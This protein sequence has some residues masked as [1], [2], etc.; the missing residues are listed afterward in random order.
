MKRSKIIHLLVVAA[1]LQGC[2]ATVD[3]KGGEG[4]R[5]LLKGSEKLALSSKDCSRGMGL[6][7]LVKN[8]AKGSE[9]I[10][11]AKVGMTGKPIEGDVNVY[12]LIKENHPKLMSKEEA[13][14]ASA[15]AK[16]ISGDDVSLLAKISA[17][18][19]EREQPEGLGNG[20]KAMKATAGSGGIS[21]EE[22][23]GIPFNAKDK[24][25]EYMDRVKSV[26]LSEIDARGKKDAKVVHSVYLRLGD[27]FTA[28]PLPDSI[29]SVQLQEDKKQQP[30]HKAFKAEIGKPLAIQLATKEYENQGMIYVQI[31]NTEKGSANQA[32]TFIKNEAKGNSVVEVPTDEIAAGDYWMT[33]I[34]SDHIKVPVSDEAGGVLCMEVGTGVATKVSVAAPAPPAS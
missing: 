14:A 3:G 33:V 23:F 17:D 20:T 19:V 21:I 11:D 13:A 5:T 32:Y 7:R 27:E 26:S 8:T 12:N 29:E 4:N 9:V 22:E 6:I 2:A 18:K 25:Y 10:F 34:R 15:A 30:F 28:L 24:F 1:L 16:G 31:F